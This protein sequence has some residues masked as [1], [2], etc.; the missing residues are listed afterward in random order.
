MMS[1]RQRLLLFLLM[2]LL[3]LAA[4]LIVM[5]YWAI[6]SAT[7]DSYDRVLEGSALAIADR[8]VLENGSLVVDL[9]Y[10]ALQMLT[11]SAE[12]RVF[13]SVQKWP[14]GDVVT[15]YR[16]LPTPSFGEAD[17]VLQQI[18]FRGEPMRMIAIRDEALSYSASQEFVVLIAETL[19]QRNSVLERYLSSAILIFVVGVLA[20]GLLTLYGVNQGLRPLRNLADAVSQ[21]SERDLR[22]I[23]RPVP[24]EGR[25]LVDEINALFGRLEKTL[26]SHRHF[27]SN[28]AHQLRTPLAEL[29]TELEVASMEGSDPDLPALS[30]RVDGLAH[31]VEQMLLLS[32]VGVQPTSSSDDNF[33][34]LALSALAHQAVADWSLRAYRAGV[35]LGLQVEDEGQVSG[36]QALLLEAL[37]NLIDNVIKHARG[38][39]IATITVQPDRL[40]VS[41]DGQGFREK[42]PTETTVQRFGL[43]IV[44]EIMDL[45]K[46]RV[47]KNVGVNARIALIFP[48]SQEASK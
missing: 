15:G 26:N 17:K 36:H 27:V 39:T 16:N 23:R 37:G 32:R 40:V 33:R 18:D 5:I 2:P 12:D 3:P 9:P 1:L 22:A 25:P 4:F 6:R 19:G 24:P 21:R 42:G 29:K 45:H 13:Y 47:E 11:N 20:I 41:D 46:G 14:S 35:D 7:T 38:A 28:T 30:A 48:P 44:E 8:V 43:S 31:L 34:P 10:A